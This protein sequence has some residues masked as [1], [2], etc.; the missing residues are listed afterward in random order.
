M[1]ENVS[2]RKVALGAVV[3]TPD[4]A[5]VIQKADLKLALMRHEHCDWGACS[6]ADWKHNDEALHE[7]RRVVSVHYARNKPIRFK[8][9]TEA[10]RSATTVLLSED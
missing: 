4:A 5:K 2:G 3:I 8:I 1:N 7:G 6:V 9:I 10:D